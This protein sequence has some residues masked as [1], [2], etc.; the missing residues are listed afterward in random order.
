MRYEVRHATTYQYRRKVELGSHLAHLLP[1]SFGNC[2]RVIASRLEITPRPSYLRDEWDH[3]GNRVTWLTIEEPHD[4]F[5]IVA[6]SDVE[7]TFPSRPSATPRWESVIEAVRRGGS[8]MLQVVEFSRPSPRLPASGQTAEYAR[9]SFPPDTP[10][11][12]GVL[13][14]SR[15][16][17]NDFRFDSDATSL[18][19]TI[20]QLL[21]LRAGVCQ[22]FTH[23][24]VSGLRGIGLPARYVSGYIRTYPKQ[25]SEKRAGSDVSHAWVEAWLGPRDGWIGIDPTND[26]VVA[27]EHVVLGWGRDFSD[28]S[29]LFGVILGGGKHTLKVAVDLVPKP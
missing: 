22:D 26:L 16:I 4:R 9:R 15:R 21:S 7:V 8:G 19:T 29:P 2:Q 5:E 11:L 25:G 24:M 23:L 3:F 17:H 6:I 18:D 28:I 20:G 10:V 27:E 1:R 12:D 13:D 14:L